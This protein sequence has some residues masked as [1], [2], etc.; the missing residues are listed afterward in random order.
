MGVGVLGL[1]ADVLMVVLHRSVFQREDSNGQA[2]VYHCIRAAA[3]SERRV[4]PLGEGA[5]V[6]VH[7]VSHDAMPAPARRS[8]AGLAMDG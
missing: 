8:R 3:A 1:G 7:R 5:D 4:L 2:G 6:S